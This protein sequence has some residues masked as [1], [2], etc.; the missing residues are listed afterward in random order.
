MRQPG[1]AQGLLGV[2]DAALVEEPGGRQLA[3]GG[4][5]RGLELGELRVVVEQGVGRLGGR[6]DLGALHDDDGLL[7][8]AVLVEQLELPAV[9]GCA[10]LVGLL[11]GE[12][13]VLLGPG[14]EVRVA[15]RVVLDRVLLDHDDSVP[16][17]M[18]LV[19]GR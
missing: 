14:D 7:A 15:T 6:G 5:D 9:A 8:D 17:V 16:P 3:P 10:L 4:G 18:G 2:A 11:A 19:V 1:V 13:R 12:L